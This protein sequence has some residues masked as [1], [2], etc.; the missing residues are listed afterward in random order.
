MYRCDADRLFC[1]QGYRVLEPLSQHEL[2]STAVGH[3][4]HVSVYE[5]T[6]AVTPEDGRF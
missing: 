2:P 1:L 6:G 4:M 5:A 3:S